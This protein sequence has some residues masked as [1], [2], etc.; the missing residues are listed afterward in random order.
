MKRLNTILAVI[1]PKREHQEALSRAIA[2][3]GMNP[4]IQVTA[5]RVV[6]DFSSD[7]NF[8]HE[9]SSN[10]AKKSI[11][12]AHQTQLQEL[13]NGYVKD[14]GAKVEA[15]VCFCKDIAQGILNEAQSKPY[16]LLIK[17]ANSHGILDSILF[18]PI[19]WELL[20][21]ADCPVIIAKNEGWVEH[22]PIVVALDFTSNQKKLTNLLILRE[23]QMFARA[24]NGIIHLVNSAPIM[25]PTVM[26]EIPHY[27]PETYAQQVVQEHKKRL[28]DFA[29]HHHIPKENCH[30]E[31]GMPDD[32]IPDLCK[33]LNAKTV[34]IGSAGRTGAMA[35]LV[36]NT[37][38][39]IVDYIDADLFV[40]NYK[41]A[42]KR[43]E[44]EPIK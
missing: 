38:E 5:L 13:V 43:T 21:R 25:L 27:A 18:T 3:C 34:F 44:K 8:V 17:G 7:I 16:D 28:L 29:S 4:E 12:D 6:Y 2:L 15:K 19:D 10:D 39:E 30:V 42:K 41:A 23:A 1:E 36:G 37:C 33:K 11:M 14:S 35:A 9:L 20:R 22:A 40:I 24:T 26:L 32:V 31:N